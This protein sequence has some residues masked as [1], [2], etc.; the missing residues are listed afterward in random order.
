MMQR[1]SN[2]ISSQSR[3]CSLLLLTDRSECNY[4]FFYSFNW[5]DPWQLDLSMIAILFVF[6]FFLILLRAALL[7][8]PNGGCP[9]VKDL[10]NQV[11]LEVRSRDAQHA[12]IFLGM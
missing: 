1:P 10:Q 6:T 12:K 11:K 7:V 5:E 3:C 2:H 4:T 9:L 8:E